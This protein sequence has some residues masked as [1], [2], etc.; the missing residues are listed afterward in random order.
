M[1]KR[2]LAVLAALSLATCLLC[3]AAFPATAAEGDYTHVETE[4]NGGVTLSVSY[5]D[6]AAGQPMTLHVSASGGSGRYKY[7]M[8]A[9]T[10]V[11]ADGSR[12]SVMDPARM[13]GYTDVRDAADYEFTPMAS[14]T[15][16]LQFQVMDMEDTGLYLRK[17]VSV[18]VS[19]PDHPSVSSLVAAAVSRCDSETDGS[20]YQ[21]A[22][23][24]HDWLLDQLEYDNSLT[25][26]SAE[27]ALCR[28]TGTC[29]AY[30][31]A[32]ARL[33]TA[34]GI[35]N[36]ETRDT[37]DGHTWNAAKIE[38]TWCQIDCTWDDSSD[39]WYGFDQRHLYFGLSDEL[40]AIAHGKWRDSDGSTYGAHE[41]LLAN[42]YFVRSGEAREWAE[43][44]VPEIQRHLDA[45]ETSFSLAA[46]NAS[47]P[48]SVSGIINGIVADQLSGMEW[49]A[50]GTRVEL[51]VVSGA[52]DFDF[53]VKRSGAGAREYT[54]SEFA[55]LHAADLPDGTYRLAPAKRADAA[56]CAS[57]SSRGTVVCVRSASEWDDSQ[58]WRVSH[59]GE[60]F[61]TLTCVSS[62]F[63]LDVTGGSAARGASLELWDPNGAAAQRWVAVRSGDSYVLVSAVSG[64]VG[65]DESGAV[66]RGRVADVTGGSTSDGTRLETWD[67]NGAPAQSFSLVPAQTSSERMDALAGESRS[68]LA[69]GTYV[70]RARCSSR[71]VL[72][73]TGGSRS[74]GANVETWSPTFGGGQRWVV[75]HDAD[76][77]VTLTN[78]GS[79]L[80][81]DVSGG[82]ARPGDNV[83][84]WAPSGN[85][86]QKWVAVASGGGVALMSAARPGVALDVTGGSS[87]AGAN[88]EVWDANGAASQSFDFLD[89]APDVPACDRS[90]AD[91]GAWYVLEPACA[92]GMAVDVWGASRA[93]GANA[94]TWSS[95]GS[96]G[97]AFRLEWHDGYFALVNA[98]SGLR[99]AVEGSDVVPGANV[100]QRSGAL[101]D[102]E[103]FSVSGNGDGTVSLVSKA[104]GLALDVANGSASAGANLDAWTPHGGASQRFR[105]SRRT[106]ALAEGVY[107]IASASDPALVV[108]LSGSSAADGAPVVMWPS[109]STLNQ[110]WYVAPVAGQ[111][112]VYTVESLASA[113]R[114]SAAGGT[115]AARAAADGPGQWWRAVVG[116][117]TVALE[118]VSSPGVRLGAASAHAG[119]AVGLVDSSLAA[120]SLALRPADASLPAGTYAV[121]SAADPSV[122]LDVAG[123][124]LS[125]GANVQ[126]WADGGTG[127]QKWRLSPAAGGAFAVTNCQSGRALDVSGSSVAPAT[128]VLQ[129]SSS[130]GANQRWRAVYR[131]GGWA[132]VSAL[133]PSLVLT[134]A[135]GASQGSNA[136]VDRD[137]GSS[138]QRFTF[139]ATTYMRLLSP[140]QELIRNL[141]LSTPP[142]PGGFCAAWVSNV[143]ERAGIANQ[144]GNANDMY[145][146]YCTSSSLNDLQVGMVVAVPSHTH[147]SAGRIYGH[148]GIYIGD[149]RLLD[150]VYGKVRNISLIEW[151]SYYG[152]TFTPKW[153]WYQRV[154]LL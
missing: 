132:L 142:T 69:D 74:A 52:S 50:S 134:L 56:V 42:N 48:E 33:L 36:E 146:S 11:D 147:T 29:Q 128:N 6:P 63:A 96:L 129:W 59:D 145:W 15:Y 113:R 104:T 152:T 23:W 85:R 44:Y 65:V 32:Y 81:L 9:P 131:P 148:I 124:S 83:L 135:G 67:P 130:G 126:A 57:P 136:V 2:I 19:D 98:S 77:Y 119:A 122:V 55:A 43:A 120:G 21:K 117:G 97:Q 84:Q 41:A 49:E 53:D 58:L 92:P 106:S 112:G 151:L 40:M 80:A 150:S 144:G 25:W 60:G 17:T 89:A 95:N 115:V 82:A 94:Q 61:V 39:T 101:G 4:E 139:R 109:A 118:S 66:V 27:S 24:L 141:A 54:P 102:D 123:G 13:P 16:Q 93:P 90:V 45:G 62:G 143:F 70:V 149:G 71:M 91:E 137:S 153:G 88:V 105:L 5:D 47:D 114:L 154:S 18:A 7:Y 75:S 26:S 34:A 111:D 46:T 30:Q 108:D 133:D 79:G 103:L 14:G 86:N 12:E 99:L 125:D 64:S 107:S 72:D 116:D 38:G 68:V 31:A 8:S 1:K 121:R 87:A 78:D 10:Y 51:N 73:V 20:E 37:G 35:E 127:N 76:G 22:L 28:G 3:A 140:R 110:R 138:S 100:S